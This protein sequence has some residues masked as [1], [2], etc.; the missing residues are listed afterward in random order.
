M[1]MTFFFFSLFDCF[2]L[3]SPTNVIVVHCLA[4]KGRTGTVICC[5][6]MYCGRIKTPEDAL[7][8]YSQRRFAI[9]FPK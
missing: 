3:E 5:Y 7:Q 8:Y 9:K 2:Y 1:T 6:L 4:G